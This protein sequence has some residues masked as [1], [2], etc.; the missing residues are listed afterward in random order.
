MR[1]YMR[2]L[3]ALFIG[4]SLLLL[5]NGLLN[6]LVTLAGEVRGFSTTLL[7]VLS[8]GY[9][10]GFLLGIFL[11]V[12]VIR[13][14]GHIRTFAF[15]AALAAVA[16]LTLVLTDLPWVWLALRILY[17][18]A[19]V[20]LYAVIESWLNAAVSSER[21]GIVFALYTMVSLGSIAAAQQLLRLDS[22]AAVTLFVLGG[23][24]LCLALTPVTLTRLPQP[25]IMTMP[26]LD[27]RIIWR[28][29]PLALVTSLFSGL[30]LGAFWG[31]MPLYGSLMGLSTASIGT[32]MSAA[33]V[34]GALGQLPIGY[35]SDRHDRRRVL[36]AVMAVAIVVSLL[37]IPLD[38][39]LFLWV[40]MGLWGAM[41][42]ALYPIAIAYMVDR[43]EPEHI[44]S[45]SSAALMAF[46]IGAALGPTG[47][48]SLMELLGRDALPAYFAGCLLLM[49]GLLMLSV[50]R[51]SREEP[52]DSPGH[53]SPMVRSTPQVLEMMPDAPDQHEAPEDTPDIEDDLPPDPAD[54]GPASSD[55]QPVRP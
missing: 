45:G 26:K 33:I 19:L 2:P 36:A 8:S 55:E 39:S 11:V 34:G 30:V 21:R 41:V 25:D 48:A 22:P 52:T 44:V 51:R 32:L 9:F 13:R 27:L 47:A 12:P 14:V 46:G 53:Y 43:V 15:M 28:L 10:L 17:G 29:A 42:F 35:Y 31:L 6:T 18:I 20:S 1:T 4:I 54:E 38:E 24:L 3:L 49:M 23:I 7:G 40:L 37:M 5:G 50:R 16:S